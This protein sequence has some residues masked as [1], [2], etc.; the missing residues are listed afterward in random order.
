MDHESSSGRNTHNLV[1]VNESPRTYI[2]FCHGYVNQ[3]AQHNDEIETI[4]GI[5]KIILKL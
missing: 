1:L 4:P 3:T 5:A 2:D